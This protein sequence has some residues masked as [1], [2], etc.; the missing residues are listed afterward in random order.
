VKLCEIVRRNYGEHSIIGV[1]RLTDG[2]ITLFTCVTLELPDLNNAP[3]ISCI[4]KGNY[5][6]SLYQSPRH[7]LV[8]LVHDVPN[9]SMI[10]MHPANYSR[11]LKGCIALGMTSADIDKDG[12]LDVT[13]SQKTFKRFMEALSPDQRFELLIS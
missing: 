5:L 9:R 12:I 7:G 8:P 13:S 4:P 2:P 11:E 3:H 10:E 1:L 6:C